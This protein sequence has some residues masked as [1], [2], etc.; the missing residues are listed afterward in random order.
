MKF[1]MTPRLRRILRA[2]GF[3]AFYVFALIIFAY[4][5][6]PYQRL[7]DRI[8]QEFN[9]RQTGPDPMRLEIDEL[10]AY[11]LTG[12]EAEGIRLIPSPKPASTS[13]AMPGV[14]S[15]PPPKPRVMNIDSAHVRVGLLPLLIGNTRLA[16]GADA[17]GGHISGN[18]SESDGTRHLAV[19][20][21]DVSL[22]DAPILADTVGLPMTGTMNGEIDFTLP[23]SKLA[24]A[25]GTVKIKI[26]GLSVG[27]GKA[28]IR[29][30]IALPKV[31]AGTL[32]LDGQAAA[33]QLKISKFD[34][35]G[36]H[37][38][39]VAEGSIRLRD[40]A[41]ASLLNLTARFKLSDKYKNQNDTTRGIFGAPGSNSGLFDLD[42]KNRRAKRPDGFYAWRVSGALSN[43]SYA[44]NSGAATTTKTSRTTLD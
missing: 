22:A 7:R 25:E 3:G 18:S 13:A 14:E 17:F 21:E 10:D 12:V 26:D 9:L 39:F 42:P 8:V 2:V 6:F 5:T 38:E 23:E 41:T 37:L 15:A 36:P 31:E 29:D 30:T 19:E 35:A 44:P 16:F 43:P 28:K 27:D 40:P 33:G 32:E 11:W 4:V 34:A 1:N 24:K 20:L